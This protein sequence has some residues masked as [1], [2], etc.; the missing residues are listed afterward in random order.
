MK[1][2][3]E[4]YEIYGIDA[5]VQWAEGFR[6][7]LKLSPETSGYRAEGN[8]I[9]N[10]AR[11]R[12]AEVRQTRLSEDRIGQCISTDNPERERLLGLAGGMRVTLQLNG[13]FP[14]IE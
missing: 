7:M 12:L 13:Q 6:F 3:V 1:E 11:G 2:L 9:E 8:S 4:E 5:A 14:R 10:M